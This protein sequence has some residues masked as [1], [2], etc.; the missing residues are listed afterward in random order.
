[1]IDPAECN[2]HLEKLN[3][4]SNSIRLIT[5]HQTTMQ[6][7]ITDNAEVTR[8]VRDLLTTFKVS[9]SIAKYVTNVGGA[10]AIVYAGY[11]GWLSK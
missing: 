2:K 7:W 6:G 11:K 3:E 1:M 9:R 4:L 8:D 5:E 10:I